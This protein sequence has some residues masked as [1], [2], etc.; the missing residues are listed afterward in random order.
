MEDAVKGEG[1]LRGSKAGV[2]AR[3][4]G[5][6]ETGLPRTRCGR[7][8]LVPAGSSSPTTGHSPGPHNTSGTSGEAGLRKG[9]NSTRQRGVREKKSSGWAS[10]CLDCQGISLYQ[11]NSSRGRI[12][13]T[14]CCFDT[15]ARGSSK[16][17]MIVRWI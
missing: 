2:E 4:E 13:F 17:G 10:I 7:F 15:T 9:Q 3:A 12:S 11:S 8:R 6:E 1:S 16:N 5:C 14:L